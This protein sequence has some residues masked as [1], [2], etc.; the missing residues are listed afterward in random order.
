MEYLSNGCVYL[1]WCKS[2]TKPSTWCIISVSYLLGTLRVIGKAWQTMVCAVWQNWVYGITDI[3]TNLEILHTLPK[4][5]KLNT[6]E[7]YEINKHYK[8]S[9]T[10]ILNDQIHYKSY[11]L[12]DTIIHS[13]HNNI[14]ANPTTTN[15][16]IAASSTRTVNHWKWCPWHRKASAKTQVSLTRFLQNEVKIIHIIVQNNTYVIIRDI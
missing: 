14:S 5:P 7:Q 6:T 10:N 13:S 15:R 3:E 16:N 2:G 12:F 4:G 8:Q 1:P 9:P 11:T